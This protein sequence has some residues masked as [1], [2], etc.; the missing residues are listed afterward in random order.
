MILGEFHLGRVLRWRFLESRAGRRRTKN[1][2]RLIEVARATSAFV[3]LSQNFHPYCSET[4][5][6]EK[7]SRPSNSER[8]L[9]PPLRKQSPPTTIP[10]RRNLRVD[11]VAVKRERWWPAVGRGTTKPERNLVLFLSFVLF[12]RIVDLFFL[13]SVILSDLLVSLTSV[14]NKEFR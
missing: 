3:P 9:P 11:P 7:Q 14:L 8:S 1:D 5:R 2:Q 10:P 4:S 13:C 12:N 6:P